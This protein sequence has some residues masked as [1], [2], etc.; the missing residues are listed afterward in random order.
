MLDENLKTLPGVVEGLRVE[1]DNVPTLIS[2]AKIGAIADAKEQTLTA[3]NGLGFAKSTDL[4]AV[5]GKFADYVPKTGLG[6]AVGGLKV[7]TDL[8][9]DFAGVPT[10]I[11]EAKIG[12]IADAKEQTLTAVNGLG[13]AKTADVNDRFADVDAAMEELPDS[14]KNATLDAVDDRGFAVAVEVNNRFADMDALMEEIPDSVKNATLQEV[15]GMGFAKTSDLPDTSKFLTAINA[16]NVL[17]NAWGAPQIEGMIR[18][19]NVF[20]SLPAAVQTNKTN[21]ENEV[22]ARAN[23]ISGLSSVYAPKSLETTVATLDTGL[24][25]LGSSLNTLGSSVS[26]L[27]TDFS[28]LSSNVGKINTTLN[29]TVN[30]VN[31]MNTCGYNSAPTCGENGY[32]GG[33]TPITG[34]GLTIGGIIK[35]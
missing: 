8:Q 21:I 13:F 19:S 30:T 7:I 4:Q 29:T 20:N 5:D 32:S 3:V 15:N 26:S 33:Y 1:L 23:A 9:S 12:A 16:Y 18:K 14:I 22:S 2:E 34:T 24:S 35:P 31:E 6:E 10:L 25:N 27:S 28:T 11:S 17:S